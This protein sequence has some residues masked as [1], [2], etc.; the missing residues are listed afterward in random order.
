MYLNTECL[1]SDVLDFE[2]IQHK[3]E[4]SV[5]SQ[6]AA[7]DDNVCRLIHNVQFLPLS[8]FTISLFCCSV[9]V[10]KSDWTVRW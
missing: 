7:A 5:I 6:D 4:T 2:K 10:I 3:K 9:M 1:H 8:R